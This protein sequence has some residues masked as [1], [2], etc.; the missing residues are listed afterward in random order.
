MSGNQT[1]LSG[2]LNLILVAKQDNR[3]SKRMWNL[4]IIRMHYFRTLYLPCTQVLWRYPFTNTLAYALAQTTPPPH[5]YSVWA[6]LHNSKRIKRGIKSTRTIMGTLKI[7]TATGGPRVYWWSMSR[8]KLDRQ[9]MG[10]IS[11][12]GATVNGNVCVSGMHNCA[13]N[14]QLHTADLYLKPTKYSKILKRKLS[15]SSNFWD[16]G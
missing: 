8:V 16:V 10:C 1:V 2:N 13:F 3:F 4:D 5:P 15:I 14:Q 7:T 12:W 9:W 6:Y 11:E